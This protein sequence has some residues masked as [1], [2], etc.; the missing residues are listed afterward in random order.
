MSHFG[1]AEQVGKGT[2]GRKL[3]E[4]RIVGLER[5]CARYFQSQCFVPQLCRRYCQR[6]WMEEEGWKGIQ[7]GMFDD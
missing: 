3:L 1:S 6:K 7:S 4:W 5:L 2:V